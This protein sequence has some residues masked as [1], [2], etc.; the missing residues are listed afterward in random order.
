MS[1][2]ILLTLFLHV[3]CTRYFVSGHKDSSTF[4]DWVN[5]LPMRPGGF[6]EKGERISYVV[7]VSGNLGESRFELS[8]ILIKFESNDLNELHVSICLL[9]SGANVGNIRKWGE[10]Y[11]L[12][13]P[14]TSQVTKQ[15]AAAADDF[16]AIFVATNELSRTIDVTS[17]A[18]VSNIDLFILVDAEHSSQHCK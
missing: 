10:A 1:D 2:P 7:V 3:T 14:D 6:R 18:H 4:D 5:R 11:N 16:H 8:T 9:F 13:P 17:N 15:S 12:P